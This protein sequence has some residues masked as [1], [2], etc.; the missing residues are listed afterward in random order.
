MH[1]LLITLI[2]LS[3]C[4]LDIKLSRVNTLSYS[5]T[6]DL[7]FTITPL[8]ND[9]FATT[10]FGPLIYCNQCKYPSTGAF[11]GKCTISLTPASNSYTC[12]DA[13]A[14]NIY[15]VQSEETY[16]LAA[17][18]TITVTLTGIPYPSSINNMFWTVQIGKADNT[19]I[20][21]KHFFVPVASLNTKGV[22]Q[23]IDVTLPMALEPGM[24]LLLTPIRG[25]TF[26][27]ADS[28]P[29]SKLIESTTK[30]FNSEGGNCSV[31]QGVLRIDQA[32]TEATATISFRYLKAVKMYGNVSFSLS[33][34]SHNSKGDAAGFDFTFAGNGSEVILAS[35]NG[36][37]CLLGAVMMIMLIL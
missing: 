26:K 31:T 33:T 11:G 22:S 16:V 20:E 3:L 32:V 9:I 21:V 8:A 35:G 14:A 28:Q 4:Q 2:S 36:I 1:T 23:M 19:A 5:K 10:A 6:Y 37:S 12:A 24:G 13:V 7:T 25:L 15:G 17:G 27:E 30:A 18:A 29:C 34:F